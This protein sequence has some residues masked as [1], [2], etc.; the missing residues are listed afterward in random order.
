MGHWALLEHDPGIIT[1]FWE[2]AKYIQCCHDNIKI[3]TFVK[4]L[5][6]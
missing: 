5:S 4:S 6:I 2:T 1:R 3:L